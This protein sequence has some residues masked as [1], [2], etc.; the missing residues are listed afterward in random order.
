MAKFLRLAA[1]GITLAAG[2]LFGSTDR[3]ALREVRVGTY[4]IRLGTG[5][6]GTPNA[7]EVRKKDLVAL[8]RKLDLDAFGLQDYATHADTRSGTTLYPSDHFP[9]TATVEL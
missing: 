3:P 8:I 7:W 4:N 1:A 9:V 6:K 2:G 5:D